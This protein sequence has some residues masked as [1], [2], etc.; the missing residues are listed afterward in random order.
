LFLFNAQSPVAVKQHLIRDKIQR[1]VVSATTSQR[2]IIAGESRAE[3]GVSPV[4]FTDK[5][6]LSAV[7]IAVAD[8]AMSEEY[9]ALNEAHALGSKRIIVMGIS[10]YE[11]N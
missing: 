10:S 9:D 3:Q 11:M 7:S 8:G 4:V 5:T 6:G 1:L 2:V